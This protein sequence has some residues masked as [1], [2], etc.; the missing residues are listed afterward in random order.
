MASRVNLGPV[1]TVTVN[2]MVTGPRTPVT[3]GSSPCT[4]INQ[5]GTRVQVSVT[6]GTVS[7][8]EMD[9]DGNTGL[10]DAGLLFGQF[11]LNPLA[12]LRITYVVAPTVIFYPL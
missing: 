9:I 12:L 8:I 6:G 3:L 1:E 10:D 5:C 2:S 7:L 11:L 4:L